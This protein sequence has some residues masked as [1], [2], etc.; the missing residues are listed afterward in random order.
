MSEKH[1]SDVPEGWGMSLRAA[2]CENCDWSYLLPAGCS[3]PDCPHCF[4]AAL[5]PLSDAVEALP[6]VPPPEFVIPFALSDETLTRRVEAFARG[7]PFPPAD[8]N[9]EALRSWLQ[10]IF[11]PTWLVDAEVEAL[12]EAEV[13]FTYQVVSHEEH[14][15]DGRQGWVTRQVEETRIRWEPRVGRLHR[16]YH[17]VPAAA[18][19][20]DAVLRERLGDWDE[21]AM[22]PYHSRFLHYGR[23]DGGDGRN[24]GHGGRNDGGGDEATMVSLPDRTPEDAW[25]AALPTVRKRAAEECRQAADADHLRQFRWKPTSVKRNWTMLLVPLYTTT[26]EDDEGQARV[27][28]IHGQTGQIDGERRASTKRA[29]RT[30]LVIGIV[31]LVMLGISLAVAATGLIVPPLAVV[32][33]LGGLVALLVGAGALVPIVRVWLFNRRQDRRAEG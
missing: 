20:E 6:T 27:L 9:A 12:W 18:L 3:L 23:N 7:I 31:A 4:Q 16:T 17:N 10:A 26:Y 19:E 14:Y 21:A 28:L 1:M 13:G 8:L 25:S 29:R 32:G 24:D 33:G 5:A 15:D 30:A 2:V 11:L 22:E